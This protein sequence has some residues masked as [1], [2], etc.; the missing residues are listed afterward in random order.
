[1]TRRMTCSIMTSVTPLLVADAAQEAVEL[2]DS[3]DAQP[4]RRL[5]E[6]ARLRV[7]DQ[8]ARDLDD[9]LLAE[10]QRGRRPVGELRQADEVERFAR[11]RRDPASSARMRARPERRA[12]EARSS[13]RRCRPVIMFS[14]T[15]HA[16]EKLRG[17]EGARSPQRGDP[18]GLEAG[19]RPFVETDIARSRARLRPQMTL[20]SV[21]L[22][23]PFGPMIPTIS[24][25][26]NV[27]ADV[28][29]A[30]TPPNE[31]RDRATARML[32][33]APRGARLRARPCAIRPDARRAS[34]QRLLPARQPRFRNTTMP[35]GWNTMKAISR[36]PNTISWAT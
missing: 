12:E 16:G 7:A 21:V 9:A 36:A 17:L 23:A 6:Q 26:A 32:M 28:E 34:M 15:R 20:S 1:M 22:P 8:R 27:D 11:A 13:L 31:M 29:S 24:P 14:S 33:P 4:H 3:L 30:C 10:G 18:V 25:G 2:L 35:C 5:V 19:D